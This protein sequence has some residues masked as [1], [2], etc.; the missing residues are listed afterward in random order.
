MLHL[1]I[2]GIIVGWGLA[3]PPGPITIEMMRRNLSYG[4]QHGLAMGLGAMIADLCYLIVLSTGAVQL[5]QHPA[6]SKI[7]A[8][9]G[10]LLL[11]YFS[12]KIVKKA[13]TEPIELPLNPVTYWNSIVTAFF[14][15][16]FSP[17]NLLFWA[18]LTSQFGVLTD[19][20]TAKMIVLAI[21][22]VLGILS[23]VLFLNVMLY[24]SGKKLKTK[25][26]WILNYAGATLLFAFAVYGLIHA[27]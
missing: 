23:W 22:V 18:S 1:I 20:E 7:V 13:K 21:G 19:G 24:F 9:L 16:L 26:I 6:V 25:F 17:F 4:L 3:V 10:A 12:Y 11:M 2:L 5:S 8:I 15:A 14:I 27:L